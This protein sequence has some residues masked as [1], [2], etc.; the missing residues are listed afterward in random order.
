M[1]NTITTLFLA[2]GVGIQLFVFILILISIITYYKNN[3]DKDYIYRAGIFTL[4]SVS[5]CIWILVLAYILGY[6]ALVNI[7]SVLVLILLVEFC[8]LARKF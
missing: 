1:F 2:L 8:V 3:E 5:V 4:F 7:Q 6:H